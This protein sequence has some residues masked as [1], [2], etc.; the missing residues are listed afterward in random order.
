VLHITSCGEERDRLRVG[1]R[2]EMVHRSRCWKPTE[3]GAV[4]TD[5]LLEQLDLVAVPA[6]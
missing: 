2:E 4:P 6:T 3:F 1:E 5:E